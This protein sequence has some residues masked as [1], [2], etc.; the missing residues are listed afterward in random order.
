MSRRPDRTAPP[1]PDLVWAYCVLREDAPGP[2]GLTGVASSAVE[3]ISAAGLAALAGHVPSAEF[4]AEPLTRNLNDLG[5]LETVARAHESV[6]DA[7]L[8]QSTIVPLRIC[9]VFKSEGRVQEMLQSKRAALLE[10][11]DALDG[12]LEW[13]VKVIVDPER[14][15]NAARPREHEGD[16]TAP[17]GAGSAYLQRRRDERGIR[18]AAGRLAAETAQLVHARL[19]DWAIDARTR[20]PQNRELSGHA[21]EMVL[22]AAYLIERERSDE[23]REIVAELE[24]DLQELGARIE[25]SGP[26]PAYNFVPGDGIRVVA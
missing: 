11:L 15:N 23:L 18:E 13:A 9:T 7:T 16:A 10:A 12:R 20:A 4:A 19:E 14:L 8:A 2:A 21:G 5:W 1:S 3:R 22:N 26:W 24:G 25:L 6:L 17:A